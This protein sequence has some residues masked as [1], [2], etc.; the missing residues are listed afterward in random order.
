M[1]GFGP[2]DAALRA[3]AVRGDHDQER[4]LE[5][6]ATAAERPPAAMPAPAQAAH[7]YATHG[8]RVFPLQPGAKRPY[9]GSH[10]VTDATTDLHR[11]TVWLTVAPES[12]LG[13]ATGDPYDVIDI[14][15]PAGEAA[16]IDMIGHGAAEWLTV[17]A[18]SAT[19]RG[20]HLWVPAVPGARNGGAE[21]QI[22]FDYRAK[23][24]YVVVPPSHVDGTM[25]R[26]LLPPLL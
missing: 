22:S 11:L 9:P 14:D 16:F 23:G 3:A 4:L 5:Q 20:L 2:L 6:A 26:W 18:V 19:P 15:G 1:S 21:Y 7:W 17:R 25:Y 10:G 8:L 24:G 12:N 13:V